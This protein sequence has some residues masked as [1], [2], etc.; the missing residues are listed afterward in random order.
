[1]ALQEERSFAKGV[2]PLTASHFYHPTRE[3]TQPKSVVM[4]LRSLI[5][6]QALTPPS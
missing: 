4:P 2:N 5:H 1:M 6:R 3:G